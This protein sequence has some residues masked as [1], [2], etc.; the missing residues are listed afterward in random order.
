MYIQDSTLGHLNMYTKGP[1]HILNA[2][3]SSQAYYDV[4]A[5]S[6]RI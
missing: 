2:H 5:P 4:G 1:S 3:V 6:Q